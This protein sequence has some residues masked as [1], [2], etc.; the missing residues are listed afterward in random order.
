MK[1]L[2]ALLI[3]VLMLMICPLSALAAETVRLDSP[4]EI[5]MVFASDYTAVT[6]DN[7]SKRGEL[8]KFLGKSEG[9]FNTL[10][11]DG[12]VAWAI[13]SDY[14]KQISV[15]FAKDG[16]SEKIVNLAKLDEKTLSTAKKLLT[17][18]VTG[19]DTMRSSVD[20]VKK[21]E[22]LWVRVAAT[23]LDEQSGSAAFL[24]YTTVVNSY[25]Y[26][27]CFSNESGQITADDRT[28]MSDFA[29]TVT[30]GDPEADEE[31]SSRVHT[32]V[33]C[34]LVGILLIVAAFC[35]RHIVSVER[36]RKIEEDYRRKAPKKPRR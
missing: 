11:A 30:I 2:L 8:I 28:A 23:P 21:G 31:T 12:C 13:S 25:C 24:Y 3:S 18:S 20:T 16:V 1:R 27:I 15:R 14:K 4:D 6:K 26:V 17:G 36:S 34:V 32:V 22:L 35:I 19:D 5:S 10:F 7:L 29:D 33:T 9:D